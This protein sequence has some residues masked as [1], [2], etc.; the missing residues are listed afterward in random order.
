MM[1]MYE[2][3][4]G[5]HPYSLHTWRHTYCTRLVSVGVDLVTVKELAGHAKIET[6]ML[7]AHF[8]PQK[9]KAAA[10]ALDQMRSSPVNVVGMDTARSRR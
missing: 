8:L 7:Y 5:R 4:N 6:T 10:L 2:R 9:M 1:G 3:G